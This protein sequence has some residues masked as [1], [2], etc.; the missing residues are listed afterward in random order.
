MFSFVRSAL[1]LLWIG[2]F[3]AGQR[4]RLGGVKLSSVTNPLFEGSHKEDGD[5]AVDRE[6][7]KG[8]R[9]TS[10]LLVVFDAVDDLS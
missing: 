9:F 5:D 3:V 6:L 4:L 7:R 8:D 2:S 10:T 1:L